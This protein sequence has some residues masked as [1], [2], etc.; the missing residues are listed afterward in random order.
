MMG[1]RKNNVA[2]LFLLAFKASLIPL[3][4]QTQMKPTGLE[5]WKTEP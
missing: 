4:G 1:E 3:M 2:S 5:I